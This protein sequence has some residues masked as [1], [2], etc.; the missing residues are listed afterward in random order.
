[1]NW[2]CGAKL[3]RSWGGGAAEE[4]IFG[5]ITTGAAND[6]QRATDLAERMVTSYGMSKVLGPLAYEQGPQNSF[7]GDGGMNPRRMVSDQTAE[8]IDQE[9]KSIVEAAHLEALSILKHNRD[10]LDAIALQLLQ[11]EVME[12][13]HLQKLLN[14][15]KPAF[16][17]GQSNQ[18]RSEPVAV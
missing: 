9:V 12:G 11:A 14:Q 6:L 8:A 15:V 1:M 16:E 2:N 18:N 7:L 3:Q 17:E 5:N 10:L 4:I 13:E